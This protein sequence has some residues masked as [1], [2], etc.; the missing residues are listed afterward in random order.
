MFLLRKAFSA[1]LFEE[2]VFASPIIFPMVRSGASQ[3]GRSRGLC[4]YVC[5]WP[6]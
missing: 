6:P 4:V 5:V 2:G 3:A 1:K